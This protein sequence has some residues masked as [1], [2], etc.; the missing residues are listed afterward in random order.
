MT[1]ALRAFILAIAIPAVALVVVVVAN[2]KLESDWIADIVQQLGP[3][4]AAAIEQVRVPVLCAQPDIAAQIPT[5]CQIS[6]LAHILMLAGLIVIGLSV[7]TLFALIPLRALTRRNHRILVVFRPALLL[8]LLAL[9]VIVILDGA[10]VGGAAYLGESIFIGSVHPF[11]IFGIGVAVFVAATGVL[12]AALTMGR[13]RPIEVRGLVLDRRRDGDL[14][15][16]VDEVARKV[17]ATPPDQILAGLDPTFFVTEGSVAA[18][19]GTY[20][21]RTLFLSMPF[22]RILSRSELIAVIG[23]ELG[24]FRGADTVYSKRFYPVYRGSIESLGVLHA[25]AQGWAG[26]PLLAPLV[27]LDLF[28]QS[29]AEVE[30]AMSRQRELVADAVGAEATSPADIGVALV[31]MEAFHAAWT[32]AYGE[33]VQAIRDR[34]PPGNLAARFAQLAALGAR[35]SHIADVDHGRISHPTDSHP[36]TSDRLRAL[37]VDV[38]HEID[39]AIALDPADPA[40]ALI[41]AGDSLES[42]LMDGLVEELASSHAMGEAEVAI[43][44]SSAIR[45]AAADDPA[46]AGLVDLME[47]I[48][49]RDLQPSLRTSEAWI[50]LADL[51]VRPHPESTAF[52]TVVAATAVP[53]GDQQLVVGIASSRTPDALRVAAG[54]RI[55]FLGISLD[56]AREIGQTELMFDQGGRV[57]TVRLVGDWPIEHQIGGLL[58]VPESDPLVGED[59]RLRKP[60]ETVLDALVER[61]ERRSG[62]SDGT[63]PPSAGR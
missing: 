27:I 8:L 22:V 52:V 48:R 50:L 14:F 63:S 54:S 18:Y 47:P 20:H 16:A 44:R 32:D 53:S 62:M 7:V 58:V 41:D 15:A 23:H 9:I 28:F 1:R 38:Q 12:R 40:F 55:R 13:S 42:D 39:R 19:D 3:Q 29:F 34:R 36:P 51:D 60:L 6:G 17:S 56:A 11:V 26:I 33:S 59:S 4:P 31:K 35:P 21:G 45:A 25:S 46:I 10:L 30:R 43:D 61:D 2:N 24:H 57:M 5:T 37:G 49:G